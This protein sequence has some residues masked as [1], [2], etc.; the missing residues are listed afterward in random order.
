MK[1]IAQDNSK[2]TITKQIYVS[3]GLVS[4]SCF[5]CKLTSQ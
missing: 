1:H 5:K 4:N 2:N 3:N